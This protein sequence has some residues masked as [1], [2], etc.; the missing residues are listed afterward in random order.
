M[1]SN[2]TLGIF[3]VFL[4]TGKADAQTDC[5][6]NLS[7]NVVCTRLNEELEFATVYC[8]ELHQSFL[9][10]EK[11]HFSIERLC[12]GTYHLKVVYSGHQRLDTAVVLTQSTV[13]ELNLLPD[14]A[15]E[16]VEIEGHQV[17]QQEIET[18]QKNEITG[19]EL[20]KTRGSTLG[21]ALTAVTGVTTI[22]TGPSIFKP[23]IHGLYGNRI[24][25]M[26]NGVRL[27]GQT[28]GAEH[29][30]EIDPFIATKLSVIKG[31]ASIRYGMDALAGV[32]LV[33]PKE[34][35]HTKSLGGEVNLVGATNGRSG[36]GSAMLEG[37]FGKR[38][39][40]LSW[41]VQGTFRQAGSFST[42]TYYLTNTGVKENNYSAALGYHRKNIGLEVFYSSFNTTIGI[43]SGSHVG[44]LA[45]LL[46]LF[47]QSQP[48][49][50]SEF[51]YAIHRG[52]Q[53]VQ[54]QTLKVKGSYHFK[55]AGKLVYTFARQENK[56]SEFGED[57]SYNQAI[58]NE[59]IPDA[60][61]QL[62][63][64]TSEL[65]WEHKALGNVSGSIGASYGTQGNS[66]QGLD[67]R[68]LIPNYRN[69]SGGLFILEKWNHRKWTIEAG[70]RYDYKW[71][72]TYTEDFTTLTKH[73]SD[74]NW[75]SF[76]GSLGAV[77]RWSKYLSVNTS[78]STGWRPPAPIELFALGIHQSAA[79]FEIGDTTLQSER[80]CNLQSYANY[81]GKKLQ[82]EIGAYVNTIDHYIYLDPLSKPVVTINGAFPAFRYTQGNVIYS[83]IDVSIDYRFLQSFSFVSKTTLIY[84]WNRSIRDYLIYA[85]AN[86]FSNG[87]TF[88]CDTLWKLR[89]FYAGVSAL[90]VA[91]QH[92]V[93]EN[94]DYVPPPKGYTL[95]SA[96]LGCSIPFRNQQIGVSFTASNLLNTVYR[97]YLNRF[98]YYANDLGR[99]FTLRV[100]I[101]FTIFQTASGE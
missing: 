41:R 5:N 53:D 59:N 8:E 26:N 36:T 66:Y 17:K 83:G 76:S 70:A 48:V 80:S 101:P 46:Y 16:E 84:A 18:L 30:P 99:N 9:T 98:R 60:Y 81:A 6:Y 79:S 12:A 44:N 71:M 28:W 32:V 38:L 4:L 68:A 63:T 34:L 96:E 27:E 73:S 75:Q 58:V 1:Y 82:A 23:M 2:F 90:V 24:L 10:D 11:S 85:P 37:A 14:N 35:L 15:L 22:Q 45:D 62:T 100:K 7:G 31:A 13:V 86:R 57:V 33:D 89:A 50:A 95:L 40:G 74:F 25:I 64:H 78:L 92:H 77:Y 3:C 93:P 56:R 65:V 61:F 69:Y 39:T 52:Y 29:A 88:H 51:S 55:N 54:H 43:Y 94:V 87:I 72:R 21:E 42:P 49:V 19:L 91:T 97:D 20:D 47:Q 67:Y